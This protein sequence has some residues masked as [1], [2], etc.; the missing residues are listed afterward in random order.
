MLAGSHLINSMSQLTSGKM[1]PQYGQDVY[2]FKLVGNIRTLNF[3]CTQQ[4]R[5]LKG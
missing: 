5:A 3:M 4:A 1:V 2:T